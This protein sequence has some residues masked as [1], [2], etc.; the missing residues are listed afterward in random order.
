MKELSDKGTYF[1]CTQCS[2][3]EQGEFNYG[4]SF[5]RL[6]EVARTARHEKSLKAYKL[7][8]VSER[9]CARPAACFFFVFCRHGALTSIT[10]CVTTVQK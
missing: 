9:I 1:Y 2:H 5:K 4:D 10:N 3:N 8:A 6:H 7:A